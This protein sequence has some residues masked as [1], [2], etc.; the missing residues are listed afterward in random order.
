MKDLFTIIT[1]AALSAILLTMASPGYDFWFAAYFALAPMLIAISLT[2]KG[3]LAGWLFGSIYYIINLRWIITAVS[4]FGNAHYAIGIMATVAAGCL[5]GLLWGLFGWIS[6]K[7]RGANLLLAGIMVAIEIAKSTMLTG[8]PMLNL[9]HTQYSF[10]PAIQIAE[11]TGAFGITLIIAYMNIALASLVTDRNRQSI[12]LAIVM[13]GA[14]LVYGFSVQNREYAGNELNVKIIQPAYSQAEKWIP[15]KK[16]DI[17]TD[18]SSMLR[19]EHGDADLL[20]LPETVYPAFLN[21]TFAGYHMLEISGEKI[22][23]IAG[24][25]RF[26]DKDGKRTYYN[27]AF[28]FDKEAVSIYDKLHL[29]PFG[30]YFPLKNLFKPIDYYFFKG[31]E[32]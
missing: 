9:S 27:S 12:A 3:L 23:T 20:I 32:D 28:M 31:A 26:V 21:T 17:M 4:D 10:A 15:E 25:I 30:E 13:L 24:G 8:F 2:G 6:I 5:L 14:S 18:V 22:P 7:K 1:G 19:Q 11:I 29:V 16:Y